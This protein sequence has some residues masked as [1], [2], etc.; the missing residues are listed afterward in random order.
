MP[1]EE[2]MHDFISISG[3]EGWCYFAVLILSYLYCM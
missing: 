1:H 2:Q 3:R